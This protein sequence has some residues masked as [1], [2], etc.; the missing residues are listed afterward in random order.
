MCAVCS[1]VA[2]VV[3]LMMYVVGI[4]LLSGYELI[5]VCGRAWNRSLLI[6]VQ[7]KHFI[8]IQAAAGGSMQVRFHAAARCDP[9]YKRP[10][11]MN[12][13]GQGMHSTCHYR[14]RC[15]GSLVSWGN[16]PRFHELGAGS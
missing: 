3:K 7:R 14:S 16:C 11:W 13:R 12:C 10:Y 8:S 5:I 9:V 1:L 15:Y 6:R 4:C 2:L